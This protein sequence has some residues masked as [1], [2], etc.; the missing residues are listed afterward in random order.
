M[1]DD[2]MTICSKCGAANQSMAAFCKKC[3][4]PLGTG[5]H[6]ERETTGSVM[7]SIKKFIPVE[8]LMAVKKMDK[9]KLAVVTAVALVAVI[10]LFALS[11]P[12]VIDMKDYTVIETEGYDGHGTAEVSVNW[13]EIDKKYGKKIKLSG[14]GKKELRE[15]DAEIDDDTAINILRNAVYL[16]AD[17]ISNLSNGTEISYSWEV[18][19]EMIEYVNCKVKCT[20]GSYIVE[21]LEQVDYFDPFENLEIKYSGIAPFGMA[22]INYT[23]SEIDKNDFVCDRTERLSNGDV[24]TV[25]LNNNINYYVEKTG[26]APSVYKKEYTVEGLESYLVSLDDLKESDLE[27]LIKKD[28]EVI[29]NSYDNISE[30]RYCGERL[31]YRGEEEYA[32][33]EVKNDK[34]IGPSKNVL[35][36]FFIIRSKYNY[37]WIEARE[38]RG[39]FLTSDGNISRIE[40]EFLQGSSGTDG[41]W[42]DIYSL[43]EF[44]YG[45][46]GD[47]GIDCDDNIDEEGTICKTENGDVSFPGDQTKNDSMDGDDSKDADDIGKAVNSTYILPQSDRDLLEI[48]DLEKLSKDECSLARNEIYARHG[49]RFKDESIQAYFD[50]CSWYKGETEPEDFDENFLNIF[51]KANR[52]LISKYEKEKGYR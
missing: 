41:T 8:F 29:W 5:E 3:G 19:E 38:H 1:I 17:N 40:Y 12:P 6:G 16:E 44:L 21:G 24:I 7:D 37:Y 48:E 9:K 10:L 32:G 35:L 47:D 49:R 28:V 34:N 22:S 18:D 27:D 50:S 14:K 4:N 46:L 31:Y 52:D 45:S 30:V 51:E 39:V 13:D 20:D 43:I 15:T 11:S 33:Q 2:K 23:G 42:Q 25:S 36:L 26:K